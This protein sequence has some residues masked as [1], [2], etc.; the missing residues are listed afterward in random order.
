MAP[1]LRNEM[2]ESGCLDLIAERMLSWSIPNFT[3]LHTMTP[4]TQMTAVNDIFEPSGDDTSDMWM[5][6]DLPEEQRNTLSTHSAAAA[7]E[8][9]S[10]RVRLQKTARCMPRLG[11]FGDIALERE[12]DNTS[13][14]PA[15]IA[16]ELEILQFCATAS[17]ENQCEILANDSCVPMLLELLAKSQQDVSRK[18]SKTPP[19]SALETVVLVL[20]LLVN[21]ANN[22]TA[23]SAR[24]VA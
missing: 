13:P 22:S 7:T 9:T 4:D 10:G 6:F 23:F 17:V 3:G 5:D 21:L 11:K 19:V 14:T 2:H 16:L 8:A 20:Q 24:F 12:L 18:S 15:S 1:L